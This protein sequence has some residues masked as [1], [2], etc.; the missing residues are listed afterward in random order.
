MQQQSLQVSQVIHRSLS[1]AGMTMIHSADGS[2]FPAVDDFAPAIPVRQGI[3]AI[4]VIVVAGQNGPCFC[5]GDGTAA[6][7]AVQRSL[8]AA[9]MMAQPGDGWFHDH[10]PLCQDSEA[11]PDGEHRAQ[12]M[13]ASLVPSL[14]SMRAACALPGESHK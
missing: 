7:R 5:Q 8:A 3:E 1:G 6:M 12:H 14:T 2:G 11:V 4:S 13:V 10:R 9:R